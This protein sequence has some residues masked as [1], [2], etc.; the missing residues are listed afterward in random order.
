MEDKDIQEQ[1]LEEDIIEE[2][3]S[4]V[5]ENEE[6]LYLIDIKMQ[7]ITVQL[8]KIEE[9]QMINDEEE[10]S[11]E[12]I[13]LKK[14]YNELVKEKKMILKEIRKND[15][16]KLNQVSIWT[17][18]FGVVTV[19]I[20]LPFISAPIWLDC[21]ELTADLLTGA[22]D[23]LDKDGFLFKIILFLVVFAFPL[24]LNIIVW[25]IYINLIK[26]KINKKV[27]IGFWITQGL[28]NLGMIIYMCFQIYG[29]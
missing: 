18:I 29:A 27:F 28:M 12:Y 7:E 15:N 14:Q 9:Q 23:S 1:L 16:S 19:L 25:E 10:Q 17:I 2:P 11:Q 8:D 3:T 4:N 24:L 21:L 22:F 13:E 5:D 6:K 20:S 26:N